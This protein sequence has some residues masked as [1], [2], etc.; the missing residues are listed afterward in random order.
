[1][2]TL[3]S[4]NIQSRIRGGAELAAAIIEGDTAKVLEL[5]QAA[6]E[7][8]RRDI[9]D[10]LTGDLR[11]GTH[12]FLTNQIAAAL[13]LSAQEGLLSPEPSER[14]ARLAIGHLFTKGQRVL[15]QDPLAVV[16]AVTTR[17]ADLKASVLGSTR[18]S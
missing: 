3:K 16:N 13:S 5:A 17:C 1:M 6:T 8:E 2:F 15:S 7:A 10:L 18:R 9:V 11:R 4:G 14:L 12:R